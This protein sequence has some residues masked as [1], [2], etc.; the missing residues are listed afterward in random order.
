MIEKNGVVF[1]VNAKKCRG[2]RKQQEVKEIDEV[3]EIKEW[4]AAGRTERFGDALRT[5]RSG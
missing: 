4:R 2:V 1:F 5:E 3:M